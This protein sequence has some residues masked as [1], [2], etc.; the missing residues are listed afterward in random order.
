[1]LEDNDR[2]SGIWSKVGLG[3]EERVEKGK[4]E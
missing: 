2:R 3:K 1:M 4:A